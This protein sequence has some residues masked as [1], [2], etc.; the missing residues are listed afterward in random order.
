M[1]CHENGSIYDYLLDHTI[2]IPVMI[3]TMLGIGSGL[4][5]LRLSIDATYGFSLVFL[6]KLS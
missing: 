2:M 5:Y 3:I 4:S 6:I 1:E